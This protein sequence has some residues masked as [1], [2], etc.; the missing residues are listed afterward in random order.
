MDSTKHICPLC[1][2]IY[3]DKKGDTA[4]EVIAG[5]PFNQL[6]ADFKHPHCSGTTDMFETC[7]CVPVESVS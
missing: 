4:L 1:D 5:T 7:T 2:Y 6:P 3:E